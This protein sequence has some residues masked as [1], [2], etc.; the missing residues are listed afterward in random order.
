MT[1]HEGRNN[2]MSRRAKEYTS[3]TAI[4]L[5]NPDYANDYLSA[6]IYNHDESFKIAL[7]KMIDKYGHVE[8]A[9]KIDMFP[10]NLTRLLKSLYADEPITD[11]TIKRLLNG[12]GLGLEM[13]PIVLLKKEA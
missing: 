1:I 10:S 4:K 2:L 9:K 5:R 8:L 3:E 11:D 7:A 13:L 12:F 6:S